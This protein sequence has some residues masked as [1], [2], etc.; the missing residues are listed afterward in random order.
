MG[1]S[2]EGPLKV[3]ALP[4]PPVRSADLFTF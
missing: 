3:F 4:K 1:G 2:G